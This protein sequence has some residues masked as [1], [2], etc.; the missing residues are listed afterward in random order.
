MEGY[1]KRI[2]G[3]AVALAVLA[4]AAPARADERRIATLAPEGSLWMKQMEKGSEQIAKAT[5][6][7]VTTK[8]YGGGSQGD[9]KDVIRKMRLGQLDGAAL[10]SVGLAM[11]YPGIRVLQLPHFYADTD[12]LDYVREKMW[13]YFQKK[14]R[15]EG[16]ELGTPGDVGWI[17]LFS[18]KPIRTRKDLS[19]A[20]LWIW[21][22]DPLASK[23]T[24]ELGI[25]GVPLGVPEVL[26]ALSS[27]RIDATFGSPLAAV[28]LQWHTKVRYMTSL[29][30][31]Y[32]IG[33]MVMRTEV[34][35]AASEDDRKVQE[36]IARKL[37]KQSLRRVRRD[38]DRALR[39]LEREGLEVVET[40]PEV[41]AEFEATAEKMWEAG[42]GQTYTKDELELVLKYRQEWRDQ[43]AA[44]TE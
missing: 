43:Q 21:Q 39:A 33:A 35:E 4:V 38:N 26:P 8:Y 40:P 29:R 23:L 30:I 10:T 44:K 24:K 42:A 25:N 20:K 13:P 31:V 32:G 2:A 18:T 1:M 16:F 6:G 12:E 37:T 5:D 22:G 3:V 17:H 41:V 28:A 11:I 9:E 15:E 7:R 14:F 34:W 36:K 27:G 19:K